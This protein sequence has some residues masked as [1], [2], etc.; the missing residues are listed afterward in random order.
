MDALR[1]LAIR[2]LRPAHRRHRSDTVGRALRGSPIHH[3]RARIMI[4]ERPWPAAWQALARLFRQI[5]VWGVR[6]ENLL[7]GGAGSAHIC[8]PIALRSTLK[9]KWSEAIVRGG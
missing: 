2:A 7:P 3:P 9:R 5:T 4:L 8:T 6:A 1:N